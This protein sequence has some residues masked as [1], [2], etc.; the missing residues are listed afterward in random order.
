MCSSIVL[1]VYKNLSESR[2]ESILLKQ[3]LQHECSNPCHTANNV[4][5]QK[6]WSSIAYILCFKLEGAEERFKNDSLSICKLLNKNKQIWST[7][8]VT[9]YVRSYTC[10]LPISTAYHKWLRSCYCFSY[11]QLYWWISTSEINKFYRSFSSIQHLNPNT[12]Q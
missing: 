7:L 12:I 3:Q 6:L 4:P 5:Q 10:L 9:W 2:T 11:D 8:L 1:H